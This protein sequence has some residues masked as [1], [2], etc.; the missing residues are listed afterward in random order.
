[1]RSGPRIAVACIL[2]FAWLC[3][4]AFASDS[5]NVAVDSTQ[6]AA[7][8]D[9][10]LAAHAETDAD[11]GGGHIVWKYEAAG[12]PCQPTPQADDGTDASGQAAPGVAA[13]ASTV[14]V[15]GQSISLGVG[16][17]LICGWLLDDAHGDVAAVSQATVTVVPF[18]G[19]ISVE[20]KRVGKALQ[21]ALAYTT[22]GPA[23]IY[24]LIQKAHRRCASN[25]SKA[26]GKS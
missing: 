6:I 13:G 26:R 24:A 10:T 3:A 20:V 4:P 16:S 12:D 2:A 19:S 23:Q 15:G 21:F 11:F 14:D 22:S 17:W 1:M 18:I 7:G 9:T 8:A 25:P 5:L